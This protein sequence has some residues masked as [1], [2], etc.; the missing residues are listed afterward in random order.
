MNRRIRVA[1]ICLTAI[2]VVIGITACMNWFAG[3]PEPTLLLSPVVING[4][5]G[6]ILLSVKNM[7]DGGLASLAVVLG[8][9]E[10]GT[11]GKISNVSVEALAGFVVLAEQFDA[12]DGGF[13]VAHS[14][15]GL[16]DGAFAKIV[17]TATGGPVLADFVFT[18]ADIT[19]GDDSNNAIAFEIRDAF[20]YYAK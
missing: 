20:A 11:S 4:D 15:A 13:L 18:K 14:C 6:E 1:V 10:Y 17:F 12:D 16:H 19:M 7:P 9:I 3:A 5:R 8:G 2:A